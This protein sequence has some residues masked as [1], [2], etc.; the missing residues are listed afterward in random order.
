MNDVS[1]NEKHII[2]ESM[3]GVSHLHNLGIGE[4]MPSSLL[5]LLSSLSPPPL[6]PSLH[7]HIPAVI[8]FLSYAIITCQLLKSGIFHT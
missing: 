1:I 6:S 3:C 7:K 5:P 4:L 8:K 2:S